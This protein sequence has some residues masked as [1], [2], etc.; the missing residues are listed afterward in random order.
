MMAVA[1]PRALQIKSYPGWLRCCIQPGP[2]THGW[3]SCGQWGAALG[4]GLQLRAKGYGCLLG[5]DAVF[6]LLRKGAAWSNC[7][8]AAD[9]LLLTFTAKPTRE[10]SLPPSWILQIFLNLASQLKEI[11]FSS[12]F[13]FE[14]TFPSYICKLKTH[15]LI[16]FLMQ[17]ECVEQDT[18]I[19]KLE[20]YLSF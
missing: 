12:F 8:Q 11:S 16:G 9:I 15:C 4:Q 17:A 2:H 6:L 7:L 1:H 14:A 20:W 10:T 3:T 18:S 13:I 5:P 19:T